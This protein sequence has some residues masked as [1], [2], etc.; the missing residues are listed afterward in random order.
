MA[1]ETE[2]VSVIIPVYNRAELVR[3]TVES[4]LEQTYRNLEVILIN[5]GSTD[6]SLEIIQ[7]L[8][9][10][11]PDIIKVITQE[12]QG[13]IAARNRGIGEAHGRYIAFLDSDDLWVP[14]KLEQQIPLFKKGVGLVYGSVELIDG[15]GKNIGYDHCDPAVQGDI[16][17]HLLVKNRMTGG[18]VVV[19]KAALDEVGL[20]DPEFKAAENWDLWIRI[21]RNYEARLVNKPVVKYRLHDSNMSKNVQLMQD[22]KRQIIS[23]HCD[24]FSSDA[25]IA[26]Y[27]KLAEADLYYKLG[28]NYFSRNEFRRAAKNFVRVMWISPTYEDSL[29]RCFR[30]LLGRRGNQLIRKMKY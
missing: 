8:Q 1:N 11:H 3:E 24:R 9:K 2:L 30:C 5:D 28:V 29:I 16:Y 10:E 25:K 12:N 22:A 26:H 13:Q 20:F 21:C 6:H 19:L 7:G 15:T 23:K 17:H 27:S 18:S 4:V 14:D